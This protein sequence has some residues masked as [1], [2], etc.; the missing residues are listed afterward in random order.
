MKRF[1]ALLCAGVMACSM[2]MITLAAN[3]QTTSNV[4][5]NASQT[6]STTTNN[7]SSGETAY[8]NGRSTVDAVKVWG[9]IV[10]DGVEVSNASLSINS[11][12]ASDVKGAD[13]INTWTAAQKGT[14]LQ[15][16]DVECSAS[17]SKVT[18]PFTLSNV[19]AGQNIVVLH[20]KKNADNNDGVWETIIP[21]KV[22]NGKVIV[23]FSSLSPI[24]FISLDTPVKAPK[25]GDANPVPFAAAIVITASVGAA[26]AIRKFFS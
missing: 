25:T 12:P 15:M 23:T 6:T 13:Y 11:L 4:T 26:A 14:V 17:F 8:G 7:S 9:N 5:G 10:I 1:F 16:I 19:K 2:S 21:D 22:E 18:I 20:W 24:A 3:S